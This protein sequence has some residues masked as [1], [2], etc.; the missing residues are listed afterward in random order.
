MY[1]NCKGN[2][3]DLSA[4]KLMGII[5]LTPDSFYG[6]SRHTSEAEILKS[7]ERML[8]EGADFLDLGANSSRPG[9]TDISE[10]EELKRLIPAVQSTLKE[11][12]EALISVDTFRS[13]VAKN[14]IEEGA[15]LI[16]DISAGNLDAL[17]MPTVAELQVPYI[18]MHMKGTPQNMK[19]QNQYEDLVSEILYYF[20][21]K[22]AQA[23]KL[24]INDLIADPGFGFAKNISQNFELLSKLELFNILKTP[25]LTG[26][27]RKSLIYKTLN[28]DAENSLNGT[29]ILNTICLQKGAN[30]LRVHDVKEAKECIKLLN[31]LK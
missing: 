7:A 15:A 6:K 14:A 29:S 1:I 20:S 16:N 11:F 4:P 12:P 17:M 30:I 27:S 9:A 19:D 24:G 31:E 25:L 23:R 18:I 2:L 5:N 3:I 26:I 8:L 22:I 10:E 13:K 21:E 28:T